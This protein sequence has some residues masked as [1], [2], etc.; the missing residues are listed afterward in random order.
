MNLM[1]FQAAG[2]RTM[3]PE[4]PLLT[5]DNYVLGMIGESGEVVDLVKKVCFHGHRLDLNAL[6]CELG[7]VSW[8]LSAIASETG[9]SL[10]EAR[11]LAAVERA[12]LVGLELQVLVKRLAGFAV[13][14]DV[15]VGD[16]RVFKD[17]GEMALAVGPALACV[18]A[19]CQKLGLSF[20][21]VLSRNV[22][23]LRARYPERFDPVLSQERAEYGAAL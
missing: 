12:L 5:S 19:L 1:D 3:D 2:R 15:A 20:F 10:V 18:E 6:G 9:V 14:L 7:D 16:W 17:A 21:W 8:Y 11:R 13:E 22:E 23:K 4:T